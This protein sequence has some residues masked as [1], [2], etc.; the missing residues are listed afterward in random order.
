M[1]SAPRAYLAGIHILAGTGTRVRK[2]TSS[3]YSQS[4]Q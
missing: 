3:E 2:V 1:R 4:T